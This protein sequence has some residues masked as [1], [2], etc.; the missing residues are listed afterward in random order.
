MAAFSSDSFSTSSFSI[1]AFSF[2]V[3]IEEVFEYLVT[4]VRRRR[5]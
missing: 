2:S 5:S 3:I 4:F 1:G